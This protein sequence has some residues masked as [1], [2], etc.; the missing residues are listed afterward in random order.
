MIGFPFSCP[1]LSEMEYRRKFG[2]KAQPLPRQI[3]VNPRRLP[4]LR[5]AAGSEEAGDAPD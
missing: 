4:L 5:G 3:E 2:G 1:L